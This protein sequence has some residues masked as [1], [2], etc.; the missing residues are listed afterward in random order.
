MKQ[1]CVFGVRFALFVDGSWHGLSQESG[2]ILMRCSLTMHRSLFSFNLFLIELLV[3][4][5]K[6][7][8]TVGESIQHLAHQACQIQSCIVSPMH[9]TMCSF[10]RCSLDE[11]FSLGKLV[12]KGNYSFM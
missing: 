2:A 9:S 1:Q 11:I 6:R 3:V 7:V 8:E 5:V 4:H 10:N 12:H